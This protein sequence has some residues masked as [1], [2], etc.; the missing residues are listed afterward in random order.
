MA[1]KD[2]ETVNRF[3]SLPQNYVGK[4][5]DVHDFPDD[6]LADED[7]CDK[8][9]QSK[10]SLYLNLLYA[11][12]Q[13]KTSECTHN[14]DFNFLDEDI[15]EELTSI[16]D[17]IQF[18]FINPRFTDKFHLINDII[19]PYRFFLMVYDGIQKKFRFINLGDQEKLKRKCELTSCVSNQ[20][21]GMLTVRVLDQDKRRKNYVPVYIFVDCTTSLKH[22]NNYYN[23]NSAFVAYC[24]E[25]NKNTKRKEMYQCHCYDM[26]F[27]Y[28]SN[29][30]KHIKHCSGCPEFICTLQDD[31]I[32]CYK[33]Y[34]KHKRDFPFTIVGDL[35]TT[36]GYILEIE[37]G[38]MFAISYCI[39]FN[40]HPLLHMTSVTCLR[41]FG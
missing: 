24:K 29:Y 5:E 25:E 26:F 38:S 40:F 9:E 18:D 23:P 21:N 27:R 15:I 8:I 4:F 19:I 6:S 10:D 30:N 34:I 31:E 33:N 3:L 11:L 37:G 12:R 2:N 16:K 35:E 22:Y 7:D 13:G 14:H 39:M 1:T 20:F 36:T 32:E 17:Q 28:K 41:T